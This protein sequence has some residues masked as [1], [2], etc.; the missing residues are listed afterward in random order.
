MHAAF[1]QANVMKES[2][3]LSQPTPTCRDKWCRMDSEKV[4]S[5][6]G[7]DLPRRD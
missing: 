2:Q 6:M 5:Q 4:R 7:F 3:G 1:D